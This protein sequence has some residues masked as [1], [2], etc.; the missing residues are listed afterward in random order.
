M[1]DFCSIILDAQLDFYSTFMDTRQVFCSNVCGAK[2]YRLLIKHFGC[3]ARLFSNMLGAKEDF[4]SNILAAM[5]DFCSI[6]LGCEA[7]LL[8]KNFGCEA[9]I[10]FKKCECVK[11]QLQR[12]QL[13]VRLALARKLARV[14]GF[15]L[16]LAR[17]FPREKTR[18]LAS[19]LARKL[20][21]KLSKVAS[22]LAKGEGALDLFLSMYACMQCL[23]VN[24]IV[25]PPI[26]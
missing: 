21:K 17:V 12:A 7:R 22:F 19:F 18:L 14:L 25:T 23:D 6:F 13:Y 26:N 4:C 3:K 11:P 20:S 1:Q 10:L 24:R 2:F 5:Q 9:S 15:W 16:A 8:F